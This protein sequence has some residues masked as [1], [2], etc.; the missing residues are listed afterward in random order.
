MVWKTSKAFAKGYF[1]QSNSE[2]KRKRQGKIQMISHEIK[3]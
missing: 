2:F 1:I 3:K